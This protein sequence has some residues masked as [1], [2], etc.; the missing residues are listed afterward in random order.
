MSDLFLVSEDSSRVLLESFSQELR[1]K[2]LILRELAHT[3]NSDRCMVYL[4]CWLHQPFIPTQ[5]RL[6]LEALL[7]ETGHRPL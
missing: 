3:L 2:Q 6:T 7:L 5:N 4:S 1:L